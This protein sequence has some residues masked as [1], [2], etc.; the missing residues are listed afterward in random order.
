[1]IERE[2]I[3]NVENDLELKKIKKII[4]LFHVFNTTEILFIVSTVI[5]MSA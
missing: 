1:M 3:C 5:G 2:T 4:N